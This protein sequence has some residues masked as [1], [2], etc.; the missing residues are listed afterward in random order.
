MDWLR[1]SRLGFDRR[2]KLKHR[3]FDGGLGLGGNFH[4]RD[5]G[6]GCRW[7]F[8]LNWRGAGCQFRVGKTGGTLEPAAKLAEA[9]GATQV[10]AFDMDLLE[11][12]SE[13]GGAAVIT[14]AKDK[15]EKFFEGG[16]V[17]RRAAQNSFEKADGFL[18][19]TVAGEKI[20]V[21]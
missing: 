3:L 19:E 5:F 14:R 7:R 20:D 17:A 12:G 16:G 2:F 10:G 18:R 15:V 21:R 9:L 6:D 11:L 13:L 4:H 8:R 1:G